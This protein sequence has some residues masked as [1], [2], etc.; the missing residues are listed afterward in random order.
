MSNHKTTMTTALDQVSGQGLPRKVGKELLQPP[1]AVAISMI[2][3]QV[4]LVF[5]ASS[6]SY[7]CDEFSVSTKKVSESLDSVLK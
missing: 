3:V 4:N 2:Q 6:E 5:P 1:A 7:L